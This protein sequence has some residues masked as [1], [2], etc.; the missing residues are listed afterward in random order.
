MKNLAKYIIGIC[1]SSSLLFTGCIEEALPTSGATSE[2]L[3][4]SA[5]ATEA[6]LWAIPAFANNVATVSAS[7]DYDWGLGSVMH[8]R[9]V[10]TGDMAIKSSGYDWYTAWS[11]NTYIGPGYLATQFIWNFHWKFIL[12]TNNLLSAVE[13]SSASDLQ[14]GYIGMAKAYRA[15]LYLDMAR[16]YEFLE[17]DAI[18]SVNSDGNNVLNLTVPIVTE[19]TTEDDARNNPRVTRKEMFD[20]ILSD[21]DTAEKYISNAKMNK[22]LPNLTAVY[23]LKARLYSWVGDYANA[24]EYAA[25]ALATGSYTPLNEAQWTN[26]NTGFNTLDSNAWIWGAFLNSDAIASALL[27]WT[28]WASNEAQYGY[29]SA[30]PYVQIDASLYDQIGD[31]D[32]RKLSFK[33]PAGS[34]LAS[35]ISYLDPTFAAK[36]PTYA[37]VKFRPNEGNYS[38]F[39][40]GSASAYP[41]MRIEEMYF[42]EMEA[43]AHQNASLGFE[44]LNTFMKTY[45]DASYDYQMTTQEALINEIILQKRIEFFGEVISFYDVKRLNLSVTRGYAGTNFEEATRFNTNGRPAWMN[46][47]IVLTEGN[48]NEGV[49][50]WN[51]PDPSGC[52]TPWKAN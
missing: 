24:Q 9:D 10:M 21:L 45:R 1:C 38:E 44:K 40:V 4:S 15:Y 36:L 41:I 17:N 52:Y 31:N 11:T 43:I 48:N 23:G 25:R 19:K 50:G 37:S 34:A 16:M 47:C 7:A 46:F 49:F 42:I 13:E 28:S 33:A 32:F 18:S 27:N 30:G 26:V 8:V 12:T 20:F 2:Q 51:N 39:K 22:T 14:L 6:L 35:K 29:S 3:A 5:K